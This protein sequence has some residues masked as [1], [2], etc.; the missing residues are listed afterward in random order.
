VPYAWAISE[1][2]RE[3]S[4]LPS[5][6]EAEIARDEEREARGEE[7]LLHEILDLRAF[8]DTKRAFEDAVASD[9]PIEKP[10]PM[11]QDLM[12]LEFELQQERH[13]GGRA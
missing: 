11:M 10:S 2:C 5:E 1:I 9:K 12:Q 6:A 7:S 8:A 4:C 13:A 3:F